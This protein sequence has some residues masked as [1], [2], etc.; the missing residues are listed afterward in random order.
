MI[1]DTFLSLSIPSSP[2]I[3]SL[4]NV[5]T[6][7]EYFHC[8]LVSELRIL[9][10][11][12]DRRPSRKVYPSVGHVPGLRP[13]G[14]PKVHTRSHQSCLIS[15]LPPYCPL[16]SLSITPGPVPLEQPVTFPK[17]KIKDT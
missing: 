17:R 4:S 12:V 7:P 10:R 13:Q 2:H 8:E 3:L 11:Y 15:P 14:T 9:T 6:S 1:H 5:S 16:S